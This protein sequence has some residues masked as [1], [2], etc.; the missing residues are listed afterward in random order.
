MSKWCNY[1]TK[2]SSG[3]SNL[4]STPKEN[5]KMNQ[6]WVNYLW[7]DAFFAYLWFVVDRFFPEHQRA[8]TG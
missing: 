1:T 6:K 8:L 4:G 5:S 2:K 3:L 7:I